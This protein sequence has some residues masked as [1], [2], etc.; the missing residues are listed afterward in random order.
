MTE[1]E[2]ELIEIFEELS[3]ENQQTFLMWA[4]VAS[5]AE[6]SVRKSISRTL[7]GENR[8]EQ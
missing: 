2:K 1:L 8:E 6:G 5:I 4:R 3:P 7:K